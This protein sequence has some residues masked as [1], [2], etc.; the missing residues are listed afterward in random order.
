[1]RSVLAIWRRTILYGVSYVTG[2]V[3][4]RLFAVT[5][6][7]VMLIAVNGTGSAQQTED[8]SLRQWTTVVG[9]GGGIAL[10]LFYLFNIHSGYQ[11]EAGPGARTAII[12]S[13]SI[14]QAAT[15]AGAGWLLGDL[16]VRAEPTLAWSFVLGPLAGAVLGGVSFGLTMGT[17]WAIAIPTGGI[18]INAETDFAQGVDT[19]YEGLWFGCRGGAMIGAFSGAL[20]GLVAMPILSAV[21]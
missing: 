13:S 12:L 20:I 15:A 4:R 18:Q 16:V 6:A 9:L 17:I 11:P 2:N 21:R 14:V 5:L 19:W 1:M 3:I 8:P 10:D 7:I